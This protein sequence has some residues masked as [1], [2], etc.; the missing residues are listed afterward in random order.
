MPYSNFT[1]D[2]VRETFQLETVQT[3]GTFSDTEPVKPSAYLT[4]ALTSLSP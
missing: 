4:D 2:S 1:F 3:R